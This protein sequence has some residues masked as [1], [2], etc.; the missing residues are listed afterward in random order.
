MVI[1]KR[2]NGNFGFTLTEILVIFGIIVVLVGLATAVL[3]KVKESAKTVVCLSNL[4]QIAVAIQMYHADWKEIPSEISTNGDAA[5]S[6]L[7]SY[8]SDVRV[9][10]CPADQTTNSDSYGSFYIPRPLTD[11]QKLF[12]GCPRHNDK[13]I[14]VFGWPQFNVGKTGK[15]LWNGSPQ[16]Q[17]TLVQGGTLLFEDGTQV[18]ID[19]TTKVGVMLSCTDQNKKLYS[20][21]C[22]QEKDQGKLTITHRGDS[23]FEVL[24]PSLIT[25]VAGTAFTITTQWLTDT[26]STSVDCTAGK[27][28]VEDRTTDKIETIGEGQPEQSKTWESLTPISSLNYS[29]DLNR[30]QP[31][32]PPRKTPDKT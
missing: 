17:G 27:V 18:V 15:I 19:G 24:T 16:N 31:P 26:C 6:V 21:I 32:K 8:V 10:K 5:K 20:A 22:V 7:L 11:S 30:L 12:L 25:G 2:K 14:A 9:F 1:R 13:A 4:K 29:K 3:L 28:A 23:Q